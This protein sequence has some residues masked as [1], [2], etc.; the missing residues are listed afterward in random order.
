MFGNPLS[1]IFGSSNSVFG[2]DIA[3]GVVK[4]V[5]LKNDGGKLFLGKYGLR[6]IP[7]EVVQIGKIKDIRHLQD[8]LSLLRD[9]EDLGVLNVPLPKEPEYV[10]MFHGAG[11]DVKHFDFRAQ[12]LARAVV[13][14][15]DNG[16]YMLVDLA[17]K[18]LGIFIVSGG[19]V[20][21]ATTLPGGENVLSA[22]LME[23]L[24]VGEVEAKMMQKEMGFSRNSE[25][26]G[27]INVFRKG[28]SKIY[29]EIQKHFLSWHISKDEKGKNNPH[30]TK[31]ILSGSGAN[32]SGLAEYLG[33]NLKTPVEVANAWVNIMDTRKTAPE[34]GFE[35]S[36]SYAV[37]LGL[38]LKHF[39]RFD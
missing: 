15:G 16:T 30:I 1:K 19:L 7:G 21:F 29:E 5:E 23:H 25:G 34:M 13:P 27:I 33:V 10:D 20:R 9:K 12:A 3:D 37:A 32:V 38:A 31:I 2:V 26:R 18:H 22:V 8:V 39:E 36:V 17:E 24:G 4:F 28:V 6:S 35:D 11:V 14:K